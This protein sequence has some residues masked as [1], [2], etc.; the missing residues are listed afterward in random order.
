MP[1]VQIDAY[2]DP[3]TGDLPEVSRFITGIELVEQRIRLRLSRG[4]GEWFLDPDGTGLPLLEWRNQ[5]PPDI[6]GILNRVQQE[7]RQIPGVTA[8]KGFQGTHEARRLTISG[9][10]FVATGSVTSIVVS[11]TSADRNGFLFQFIFSRS[12]GPIVRPSFRGP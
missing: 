1:A 3:V 10:V 2:L 4:L 5:R 11:G 9:D 7:I 8:T 12:G 6:P